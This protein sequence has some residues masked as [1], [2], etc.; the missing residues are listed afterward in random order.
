MCA[1][2]CTCSLGTN[3]H[4]LQPTP[5]PIGNSYIDAEFRNTGAKSYSVLC[6]AEVPHVPVHCTLG[7]RVSINHTHVLYSYGTHWVKYLTKQP[8]FTFLSVGLVNKKSFRPLTGQTEK[9]G[10]MA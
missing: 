5:F 6:V 1:C 8:S 10:F 2:K 9:L 3:V 7:L 4:V